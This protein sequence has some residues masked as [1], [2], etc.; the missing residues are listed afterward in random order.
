MVSEHRTSERSS[1]LFKAVDAPRASMCRGSS[2]SSTISRRP[3]ALF[4]VCG[5]GGESCYMLL[6]AES[7]ESATFDFAPE[8]GGTRVVPG[9]Q[10]SFMQWLQ[11][12]GQ[13]EPSYGSNEG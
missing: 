10:H 8:D 1:R 3:A 5:V 2:I 6:Q 7:S 9:F 13:V 11:S 12:L 4:A